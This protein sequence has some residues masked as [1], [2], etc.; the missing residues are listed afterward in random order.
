MAF[1]TPMAISAVTTLCPGIQSSLESGSRSVGVE[2][3]NVEQID[4]FKLTIRQDLGE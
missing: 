4:K 3:N 1:Q 2:G